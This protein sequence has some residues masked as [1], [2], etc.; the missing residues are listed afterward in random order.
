MTEDLAVDRLAALTGALIE[1][2]ELLA[3]VAA[4]LYRADGYDGDATE[5]DDLTD[6]LGRIL[7]VF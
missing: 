5:F 7:G 2:A 1:A 6:K 3:G 4:D